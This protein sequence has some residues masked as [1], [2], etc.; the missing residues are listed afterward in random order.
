MWAGGTP[1]FVKDHVRRGNGGA[2]TM[3]VGRVA[4]L[5]DEG[6]WIYRQTTLEAAVPGSK[7]QI[8]SIGILEREAQGNSRQGG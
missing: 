7:G 1:Q 2:L 6:S 5:F 3:E 8:C 4:K